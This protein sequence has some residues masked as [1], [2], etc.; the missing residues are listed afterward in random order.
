MANKIKLKDLK[1]KKINSKVVKLEFEL[2]KY[3]S[4]SLGQLGI[5]TSLEKK[6]FSFGQVAIDSESLVNP[7]ILEKDRLNK[8][9]N[10]P[11]LLK[12]KFD[13]LSDPIFDLD[14]NRPEVSMEQKSLDNQG[15]TKTAD[16]IRISKLGTKYK[17]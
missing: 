15:I 11:N 4:E 13:E 16:R 8:I 6:D 14:E 10:S 2:E 3:E 1:S 9:T 17:K 5:S 12:D 7:N